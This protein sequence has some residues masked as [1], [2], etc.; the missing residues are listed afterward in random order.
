MRIL[1]VVL[2]LL[3][4]SAEAAKRVRAYTTKRGTYVAPSYRTKANRTKVDNYSTKGNVNPYS[5][6]RGTKKP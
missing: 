6:A 4:S 3:A 2:V 1:L 5:G